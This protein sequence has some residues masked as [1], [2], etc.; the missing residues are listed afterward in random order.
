MVTG[1]LN[2]SS[3]SSPNSF[4]IGHCSPFDGKSWSAHRAAT[5]LEDV[6]HILRAYTKQPVSFLN[7]AI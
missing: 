3:M 5:V 1:P 7:G 2:A 4:L 6:E